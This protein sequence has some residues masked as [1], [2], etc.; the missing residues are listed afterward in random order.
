MKYLKVLFLSLFLTGCAGPLGVVSAL[1]SATT[2]KVSASA[3]IGDNKAQV[4]EAQLGSK[5][6]AKST[7]K[8]KKAEVDQSTKKED[9]KTEVGTV[10]GDLKVNQGPGVTTLV[11][12]GA[13]WP[14]FILFLLW[15]ALRR[16]R[17]ARAGETP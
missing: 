12:L 14:L 6:E 5:T 4:G 11:F 15:L 7:V 16:V 1:S 8:A 9:K 13:G 17:N 2:P 3:H 10:Q